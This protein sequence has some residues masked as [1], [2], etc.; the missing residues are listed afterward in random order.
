MR[1]ARLCGLAAAL[2]LAA[3]AAVGGP[4]RAETPV[5]RVAVLKFGTVNWLMET[6]KTEGLDAANGFT[7][8]T[9][10]LAGDAA[11]AVAF[12]S[13]AADMMVTD[14][15]WALKKRADGLAIRWTPYSRALGALMTMGAVSDLCALKGRRVGVVG[16]A[17][18]KSWL[19]LQALVQ[20]R[21]GFDLAAEVEAL[22][23]APPLMSRQLADGA[24]VAVS[25]YWH[26]VARLKAEGATTLVSVDDAL[27]ELG[28][29]PAPSLVGFVWDEDRVPPALAAG[30]EAAVRAAG[31]VLVEDDAAWDRIRPL[32]RADDDAAFAALRDAY[33]A[34]VPGLW[35]EADTA[36]A[37]GLYDIL[38]AEGGAAFTV[39]AGPFDPA[40][41]ESNGRG[42]GSD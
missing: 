9:L 2:A 3:I 16:G 5:L 42:A 15:V 8:E 19:V 23:G 28:V 14:W 32:M 34:G 20:R 21:C 40:I 1:A 30:F 37:R 29:T 24:A 6:V 26:F 11:T 13:G 33:R 17:L 18:D 38:L 31:A 12:Q 25:T 35:T 22:H 7:L 36:A 4:A 10:P 27:T 41:F 39:T